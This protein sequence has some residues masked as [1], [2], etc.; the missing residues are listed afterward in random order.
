MMDCPICYQSIPVEDEAYV[1]SCYHRFC[2]RCINEWTSQQRRHPVTDSSGRARNRTEYLCPM[3]KQPYDYILYDCVLNSYRVEFVDDEARRRGCSTVGV[4]AGMALSA[5]HRRRR[6]IYVKQA[7]PQPP[8][9][10]PTASPPLEQ[11]QQQ[12]Q[13]Q[14]PEQA[15]TQ[16]LVA[17]SLGPSLDGQH[18]DSAVPPDARRGALTNGA[19]G[20][21]LRGVAAKAWAAGAGPAQPAAAVA[22]RAEARPPIPRAPS[23]SR[24]SSK[25]RRADDPE[26]IAFVERELQAVMLQEDVGMLVQHVVG[27]LRNVLGAG[28]A[29]GAGG[30]GGSGCGVK[31]L[32][33]GASRISRYAPPPVKRPRTVEAPSLP[34]QQDFE[35]TLAREMTSFLQRDSGLFASE[36][37]LF[38][39][40][41]LNVRGYD[42]LVFGPEVAPKAGSSTSA[43]PANGATG[44]P[45]DGPPPLEVHGVEW[46]GRGF[47]AGDGDDEYGGGF[48][49]EYDNSDSLSS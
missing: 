38:L 1:A 6:A 25:L 14:Q 24:S 11:S 29:P 12:R 42:E 8:P 41:G 3:C 36:L 9:Q 4:G 23:S 32:I 17:R 43:R 19:A 2:H 35:G 28:G 44:A 26:V 15:D 22:T 31:F 46:A 7:Q 45:L 47:G 18:Q 5:G 37:Y 20:S 30:G 40:S 48:G 16:E 34:P 39:A 21:S 33:P 10:P 49:N 13:E 27:V